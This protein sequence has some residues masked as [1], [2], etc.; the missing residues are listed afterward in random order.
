C[1]VD[2]GREGMGRGYPEVHRFTMMTTGPSTS[3]PPRTA[4]S[5]LQPSVTLADTHVHS[6]K[7]PFL[8]V[9]PTTEI[10]TSYY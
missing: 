5:F 1:T 10:F 7:I 3:S 2:C 4:N 8:C 9:I 6:S